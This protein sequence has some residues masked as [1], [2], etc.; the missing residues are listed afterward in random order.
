MCH[1]AK[2]LVGSKAPEFKTVGVLNSQFVDYELPHTDGKWTMLLFYPLDFTFVC[3]TEVI[4]FSDAYDKFK[5]LNV[6]IYGVSVDSQFSHLAW[7][8]T[9]RNQGGVGKLNYPLLA[10]INKEISTKYNVLTGEG[11]AL[12][13]LFLIDEEGVI[14]HATI[15]N[16]AVGRNV[17][18]TLRLIQAFQHTK[19]S[20][21]VCPANWTPGAD[22][23]KP[24]SDGLKAYAKSHG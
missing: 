17:E 1:E 2:P 16:L 11:V 23:M 7:C 10:D 21:E 9:P 8:D 24:D 6:E 20:G 5:E 15:N 3:P 13:G 12:R 22:T 18:E 4:A 14:Q 19:V